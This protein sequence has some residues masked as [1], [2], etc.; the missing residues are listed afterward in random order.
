MKR[1][2]YNA[3]TLLTFLALLFLP[4]SA[5]AMIHH[6]RTSQTIQG[7]ELGFFGKST[8][9]VAIKSDSFSVDSFRSYLAETDKDLAIYHDYS[10]SVREIYYVNQYAYFPMISGR[11]FLESDFDTTANR[12]VI[13][14]AQ[15]SNTFESDG[16]TYINAGGANYEVIGVFGTDTDTMFDHKILINNPPPGASNFSDIYYIDCFFSDSDTVYSQLTQQLTQDGIDFSPISVKE[17]LISVIIPN[18]LYSRWF[19]MLILCDLICVLLLF[20]EWTNLK[21]KEISI[22]LLVGCTPYQIMTS[23]CLGYILLILLSFGLGLGL[24]CLIYPQHIQYLLES[25]WIICPLVAILLLICYFKI[26][27]VSLEEALK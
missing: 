7:M 9:A 3:V 26:R 4:L 19:L 11:F 10:E 23:T 17:S 5:S 2:K 13:G 8:Y 18:I 6:V 16:I 1:I 14:K 12:A 21:K 25:I 22:K 24:S 20:F 27:R 15:E